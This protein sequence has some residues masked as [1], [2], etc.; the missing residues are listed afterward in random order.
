MRPENYEKIK[1]LEPFWDEATN[2]IPLADAYLETK[3]RY[4]WKCQ[5]YDHSFQK[6]IRNMEKSQKCMVCAGKQLLVGFNDF[7]TLGQKYI[8]EWDYKKN[9]VEP[10][11]VLGS[12]KKIVWWKCSLGHSWECNT[13]DK[14]RNRGGC[15][16]CKNIRVLKGFNDLESQCPELMKEWDYEKNIVNP[17]EITYSTGKEL[18]WW[19]CEKDYRH[20]WEES[21]LRRNTFKWNCPYC[22]GK[23]VMAGVNDLATSHP[24]LVSQWDFEKN[25]KINL[26]PD[27]VTFGSGKAAWWLCEEYNHSW[28]VSVHERTKYGCPIC[29]N[30]KVLAGFNDFASQASEKLLAEWDY[31]K[32]ILKP[33][34]YSYKSEKIAWWVC[35]IE[36]SYDMRIDS[37]TVNNFNCPICANIR[38]LKGFNDLESKFPK[39]AKEWHPTKNGSLRP[40][41]VGSGSAI[42]AWWLC[43]EGH[44]WRGKVYKRTR[45][46][47]GCRECCGYGKS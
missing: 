29:S 17:D 16:F 33:D 1:H 14:L 20:K 37:R 23:R 5:D 30:N 35:P 42:Y 34:E 7:K 21:P 40:D 2:C 11:D 36:H 26:F 18:I 8:H 25:N 28:Q 22:A 45:E 41:E 12:S 44:E 9:S 32:N 13:Q 4:W 15:P 38:I 47:N 6:I 27:K 39:I 19:V 10:H 43:D 46:K 31:K 24:E 3:Y